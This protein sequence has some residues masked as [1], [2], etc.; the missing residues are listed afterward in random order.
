MKT[1]APPPG[2]F[3]VARIVDAVGRGRCPACRQASLF[4]GLYRT[5]ARCPHC[6]VFFERNPGNW[7]GPVVI[8]YG[9]ATLAAIVAGGLLVARH[10]FAPFVPWAIAGIACLVALVGHRF[11]K[12]GW[13]W[14]LWATGLV[15][16]D[17]DERESTPG[18][19]PRV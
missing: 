17:D 15:F 6:G 12:A 13:L 5:R 16:A 10:G 14:L 11:A 18:S 9:I 19:G 8:S 3:E 1:V 7:T 4:D 2:R